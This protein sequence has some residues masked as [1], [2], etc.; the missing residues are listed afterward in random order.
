MKQTKLS[1]FFQIAIKQNIEYKQKVR[2]RF[3]YKVTKAELNNLSEICPI[4]ECRNP[5]HP[6][7]DE[8]ADKFKEADPHL[9]RYHLVYACLSCGRIIVIS[10][11]ILDIIFDFFRVIEIIQQKLDT[12]RQQEQDRI[13]SAKHGYKC[14]SPHCR[15]LINLKRYS[16]YDLN[17]INSKVILQCYHCNQIIG[18]PH[19][20]YK[21]LMNE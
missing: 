17:I 1:T 15:K 11:T 3:I 10:K 5:L 6:L 16:E 9:C 13:E 20:E 19:E 7:A 8:D 2:E 21:V 14:P 4:P 18:I 12:I